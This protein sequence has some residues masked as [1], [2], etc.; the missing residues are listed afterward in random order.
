MGSHDLTL[1]HEP[2]QAGHNLRRLRTF[3]PETLLQ[4]NRC[5]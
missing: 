1:A 5:S 3:V 2:S 4:P